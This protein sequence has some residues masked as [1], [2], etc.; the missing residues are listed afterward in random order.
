MIKIIIFD[1]DD[2]LVGYNMVVPRQTYHMLNRFTP[3]YISNAEFS[4]HK[5]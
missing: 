5:K 3:F 1:F 2:T 4:R